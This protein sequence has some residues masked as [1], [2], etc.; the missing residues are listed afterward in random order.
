MSKFLQIAM[1]KPKVGNL[2]QESSKHTIL[3]LW[4]L[5]KLI[6]L[7]GLNTTCILPT[8]PTTFPLI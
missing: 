3:L 5:F 8:P 6:F 1:H 4:V 7:Y 2:L